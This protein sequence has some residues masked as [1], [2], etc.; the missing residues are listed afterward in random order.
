MASVAI[1]YD[2]FAT[3]G[4]W[5]RSRA[6]IGI[7]VVLT[8]FAAWYLLPLVVVILNSFRP[9]PEI[10]ANGLIGFPHGFQLNAWVR[11]WGQ[12]CIGGTCA[13]VSPNFFNSLMLTI[14]ATVISTA[15]GCINGYVL[16]KWRFAA[17]SSSSA[18]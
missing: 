15:I 3:S 12:Y 6:K 7:Y 11:A 18:Q 13:G 16:A 1:G 8:L 5:R 17:P 14:P 2:P 4:T 9:L 10:A